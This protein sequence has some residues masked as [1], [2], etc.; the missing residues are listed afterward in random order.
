MF[1]VE[2]FCIKAK[3]G[4]SDNETVALDVTNTQQ[5]KKLNPLRA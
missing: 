2:K 3:E 5:E 4:S 1:K